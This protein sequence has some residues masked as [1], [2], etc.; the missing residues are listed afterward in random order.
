MV[1]KYTHCAKKGKGQ[2]YECSKM[3]IASDVNNE[4]ST[5]QSYIYINRTSGCLIYLEFCSFPFLFL[6]RSYHKKVKLS[7]KPAHIRNG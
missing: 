3:T 2:I 6:D 4:R 1:N 5:D 7:K